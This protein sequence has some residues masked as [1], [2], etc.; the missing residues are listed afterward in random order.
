MH[1]KRISL[2]VSAK[3]AGLAACMQFRSQTSTNHAEAP[4]LLGS[5]ELQVSKHKQRAWLSRLLQLLLAAFSELPETE[6]GSD[7]PV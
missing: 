4:N 2:I 7:S 5:S 3:R 1:M 6:V